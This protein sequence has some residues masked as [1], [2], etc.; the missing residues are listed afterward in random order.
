MHIDLHTPPDAA[1]FR[2]KKKYIL[3]FIVFLS[4]AL[5]ALA[6]GFYAITSTRHQVAHLDN[7]ALGMLVFSAMGV[8]RFG[9]RLQEYKALFPPQIEKLNTLRKQY[10]LIERYCAGVEGLPRRFIRVE[11]EACV[12]YAEFEES[13][14]ERE[15]AKEPAVYGPAEPPQIKEEARP[16]NQA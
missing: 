8:T 1:I 16:K 7:W 14:N 15:Q 12:E 6:I 2:N 10:P 11:Y 4:F 13:K 3:W 5:V 9:N